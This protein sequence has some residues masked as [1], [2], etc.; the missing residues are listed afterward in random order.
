MAAQATQA[1]S[2]LQKGR[3]VAGRVWPEAAAKC[4]FSWGPREPPPYT[5]AFQQR[6]ADATEPG[7]G[8]SPV[9][10]A[11]LLEVCICV[12]VHLCVHVCPMCTCV[13]PCLYMDL[14]AVLSSFRIKVRLCPSEGDQ[15]TRSSPQAPELHQALVPTLSHSLCPIAQ[16][17]PHW[18][19][20]TP[21]PF[22]PASAPF[23][24]PLP[25]PPAGP[26]PL[27]SAWKGL[28]TIQLGPLRSPPGSGS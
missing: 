28:T 1:G 4:G 17:A 20:V 11:A 8:F 15:S 18:W 7:V 24:P 10:K 14:P 25:H 21:S 6:R 2:E 27:C 5:G 3:N 23:I 26:G 12:C 16:L 13:C 22:P 9:A 19:P